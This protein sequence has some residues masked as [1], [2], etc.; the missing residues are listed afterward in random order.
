[1]KAIGNPRGYGKSTMQQDWVAAHFERLAQ[2][3][4]KTLCLSVRWADGSNTVAVEKAEWLACEDE[5]K[6]A[7]AKTLIQK[8]WESRE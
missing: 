5:Q 7:L 3:P 4:G 8:A 6:P 1:M 2:G